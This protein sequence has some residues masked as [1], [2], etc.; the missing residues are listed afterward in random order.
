VKLTYIKKWLGCNQSHPLSRPK[1]D[2]A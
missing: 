1:S 2:K